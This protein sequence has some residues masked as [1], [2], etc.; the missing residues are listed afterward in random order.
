MLTTL[1][2]LIEYST[3]DKRTRYF[4]L[5]QAFVGLGLILGP[6]LASLGTIIGRAA[7]YEHAETVAN[8]VMSAWSVGL[9][10]G[11]YTYLPTNEGLRAMCP[12]L[13]NLDTPAENP[14]PT[15][16]TPRPRGWWESRRELSLMFFGNLNR[17]ASRLM[18]EAGAA[19]T[20]A[21][22]FGYGT[23]S[24]GFVLSALGLVQSVAQL[25]YAR[26]ARGGANT[27]ERHHADLSTL[28][29]VELVA[30]LIMFGAWRW[31]TVLSTQA[32]LSLFAPALS[33]VNSLSVSTNVMCI[34]APPPFLVGP[35]W[36]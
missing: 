8:L 34:S 33:P 24:A 1:W 26:R 27:L 2:S 7:G 31:H 13:P 28:E 30:I 14:V 22:Q 16:P 20:I 32:A 17:I 25:W 11:V 35:H 5:Y 3:P 36:E 19:A 29:V 18:W 15:T 10:V 4:A 6:G 23:V 21:G 12:H 9:A